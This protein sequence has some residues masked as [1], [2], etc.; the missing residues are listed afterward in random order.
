MEEWV[1]HA[2]SQWRREGIRL[3][4]PATMPSI[5]KVECILDLSFPEDFKQLYL[6]AN[7]FLDFDARGFFLS[8]WSLER[9]IDD[10]NPAKKFTMFCD[11]SL[12]VCQYGFDR[13]KP[14]IFKAYTHHQQGP[15]ELIAKSFKELITLFNDDDEILF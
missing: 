11:N 13:N 6:N 1:E 2:I 10:Y 5:E 15:V 3:N 9:I 14:G 7:G 4:P 12:S 8:L